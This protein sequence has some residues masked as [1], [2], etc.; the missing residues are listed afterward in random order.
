DAYYDYD[1]FGVYYPQDVDTVEIIKKHSNKVKF[2]NETGIH[3]LLAFEYDEE[4]FTKTWLEGGTISGVSQVEEPSWY[5]TNDGA[6]RIACSFAG[7]GDK[8]LVGAEMKDPITGAAGINVSDYGYNYMVA[9][10]MAEP[11]KN[12]LLAQ[13]SV[14]FWL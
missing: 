7:S 10:V 3:Q 8:I 12:F 11:G 4:E 5:L 9:R 13:N 14:G 6:V 2:L 1:H